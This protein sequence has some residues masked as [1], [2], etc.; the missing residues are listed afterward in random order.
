MRKVLLALCSLAILALCSVP[1]FAGSIDTTDQITLASSP[2][3]SFVFTGN[4]SGGF[5]L[6][7]VNVIGNAVGQGSLDGHGRYSIS[8]NG[9][10]I[11]SG[12]SCGAGCYNINQSA[13]LIFKYGSTA[14]NG[15]L[16]TGD[17]Q[18]LNI[19]QTPST[20]SGVFNEALV[21]DLTITGGSLA[22]KFAGGTGILQ[23]TLL[24]T[25]SESLSSLKSKQIL[26]AAIHDGT[27]NPLLLP[28]PGSL[29]LLGT[30]LVSLGG[31]VRFFKLQAR[32]QA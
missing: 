1:V 19:T 22:S 8:Q 26:D 11:T 20:K 25:S 27:V 6:N 7:L 13:D 9:A 17:L 31:V 4:G 16:L 14:T 15:S 29:A 5:S 30:G 10:V 23:I 32:R 24:F 28:E 21:V 3:D 18:L 12:T 2:N